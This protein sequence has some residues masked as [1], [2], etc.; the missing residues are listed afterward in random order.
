MLHDA[1]KLTYYLEKKEK[2]QNKKI[3][4][5]GQMADISRIFFYHFMVNQIQSL[6][7]SSGVPILY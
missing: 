4:S 3:S 2:E 6:V 5:I 7:L 1:M